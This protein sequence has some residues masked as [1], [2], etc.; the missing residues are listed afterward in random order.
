MLEDDPST[1]TLL[2][3]RLEPRT[4]DAVPDHTEATRILADCSHEA[5]VV[6]APPGIRRL[7]DIA[8]AMVDDAPALVPRL[9]DPVERQLARR[10]P[11]R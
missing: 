2:L 10:V 8:G 7:A 1:S 3:E 4:L 9:A 11:T 5:V 6:P